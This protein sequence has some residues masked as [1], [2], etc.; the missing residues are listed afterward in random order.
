MVPSSSRM[1]CE[2]RIATRCPT[3]SRRGATWSGWFY[4]GR[5]AGTWSTGFCTTRARRSF[6]TDPS[7]NPAAAHASLRTRLHVERRLR[8]SMHILQPPVRGPHR[9]DQFPVRPV[10]YVHQADVVVLPIHPPRRRLVHP[11]GPARSDECR[12]RRRLLYVVAVGRSAFRLIPHLHQTRSQAPA[13]YAEMELTHDDGPPCN[14]MD[15]LHHFGVYR[16]RVDVHAVYV[17][18][19]RRTQH[20]RRRNAATEPQPQVQMIRVIPPDGRVDYFEVSVERAIDELL[21]EIGRAH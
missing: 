14:P 20:L 19:L 8:P 1:W 18:G 11:L 5:C 10:R 15:L 4:R 7:H 21:A 16:R 3:W 13:G 17:E 9:L 6:S 12:E 2:F